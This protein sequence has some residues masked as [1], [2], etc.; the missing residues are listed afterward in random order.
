MTH[1]NSSSSAEAGPGDNDMKIKVLDITIVVREYRAGQCPRCRKRS[2]KKRGLEVRATAGG[3][4][5][6]GFI[7]SLHFA[8]MLDA[9]CLEEDAKGIPGA[10]PERAHERMATVRNYLA[11]V[12]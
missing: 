8:E 12:E 11:V 1:L 4:V 10:G 5:A 9:V 7:C 3:Q 2:P 6:E